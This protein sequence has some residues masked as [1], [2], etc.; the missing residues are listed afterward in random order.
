MKESRKTVRRLGLL[1]LEM[2]ELQRRDP[3]T[4]ADIARMHELLA[5]MD[6]LTAPEPA[7]VQP[8]ALPPGAGTYVPRR[9]PTY[10]D[11]QKE[12]WR[13]VINMRQGSPA[14][15]NI[16]THEA[17]VARA[18]RIER[19]REHVKGLISRSAMRA[20]QPPR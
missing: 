14:T 15:R 17:D 19:G 18:D 10:A 1:T 3:K 6:A 12:E 11:I 9:S 20:G 16:D 7:P 4:P 5:E 2:I 13:K 8:P